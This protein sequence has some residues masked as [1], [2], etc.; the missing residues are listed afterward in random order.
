M[1]KIVIIGAGYGGILTALGWDR[2]FRKN[3]DVTITLVDKHDYQ[4]FVSNLYEV[5]TAEEE[6]VSLKQLKKS[7]ALPLGEIFKG[8]KVKVVKAEVTEINPKA[9]T[10]AA[11]TQKFGY[12]YLV[13]AAG[14]VSDYFN[15][16]GAEK[17]ALPLKTLKD[18][19]NVK[20]Q[21]EFA[22]QRYRQDL[23]KKNMRIVVAG[24]G[25]TGVELAGELPG[26]LD[27]LAWK[28]QYPRGKI[29]ITIVDADNRLI[30]SLSPH[31]SMDA[32]ERLQDL[33]VRVQLSSKIVKVD[34]N[35]VEL[36]TGDRMEY[37]VLV[38]TTGV[39]AASLP[40]T[41]K[42]NTDRKDRVITN[43]FLQLENY[44]NIFAL[45]DGA[46]IVNYDGRPAPPSAQDAIEQSNYVTYALPLIMQN[47]KPVPYWGKKH[48]YI[49]SIGGKWAILD[50]GV[51]Y[52]TGWPAYFVRQ[53]ANLNYF[54]QVVG[55][56]KA[57]KLVVF[58]ME[59]YS[60]ND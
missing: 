6:M 48:G 30:S 15:V 25:F 19:F 9:K 35:F 54:R 44:A 1:P 50:Y 37:D 53:L 23:N 11:G 47:K 56:W 46:G 12:D 34:A 4:L 16:E 32:L 42:M 41:E 14:S 27:I 59:I 26:F 3:N 43:K 33:K 21:I 20:N 39:K 58:E 49:I 38:W 24:G 22:L 57:I 5:A 8:T 52:F 45:G 55:W 51:F 7:I 28:N 18:A 2:Q 10:V 36:S 31:L 40:F 17:F 29:E 13:L 60:R